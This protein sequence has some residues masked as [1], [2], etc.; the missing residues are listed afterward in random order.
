MRTTR[1]PVEGSPFVDMIPE[2]M[3]WRY[4]PKW[5]GFLCHLSRG[6]GTVSMHSKQAG[7]K[8]LLSGSDRRGTLPCARSASWW[9]V[10]SLS[11]MKRD[12]SFDA[13][14][15]RIHPAAEMQTSSISRLRLQ[16]AAI[17]FFGRALLLFCDQHPPSRPAIIQLLPH[18]ADRRRRGHASGRKGHNGVAPPKPKNAYDSY[19]TVEAR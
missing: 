10:R 15:Q 5:D 4:E 19:R 8:A 1:T 16:T 14:L 17:K 7:T 9:M 18:Y 13:L 11:P 3:E 6:G 2:G 12:F